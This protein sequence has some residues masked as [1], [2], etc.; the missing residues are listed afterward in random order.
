MEERVHSHLA[1]D[2]D[3][4]GRRHSLAVSTLGIRDIETRDFAQP[5]TNSGSYPN[6]LVQDSGARSAV[7]DLQATLHTRSSASDERTPI[8]QPIDSPFGHHVSLWQKANFALNARHD[9]PPED[10]H[11]THTSSPI[12]SAAPS[13]S[14]S[15]ASL[16]S[17]AEIA[18]PVP[19]STGKRPLISRDISNW[20]TESTQTIKNDR[21]AATGKSSA[22]HQGSPSH[23]ADNEGYPKYPMQAYSAL[24]TQH[25]PPPYQPQPHLFRTRSLHPTQYALHYEPGVRHNRNM[26]KTGREVRTANT[27][28][29]SSSGLFTPK[30]SPSMTDQ[31]LHDRDRYSSPFLHHTHLQVPKET[32]LAE[33]DRDSISGNKVINQY[34]I[35]DELGRGQHGKVKLGRDTKTEDK[36]AIKIVPRYSRRRRLGKIGN[37]ENKVKKEVAILK[38]A[39]HEHVVSLLEVID[40]PNRQKVYLVLEFVELGEIVWRK[41]GTPEI[42]FIEKRRL[43]REKMGLPETQLAIEEDERYLR[44]A[45]HRRVKQERLEVKTRTDRVNNLAWS[46]ELGDSEDDDDSEANPLSR[47]IT[48]ETDISMPGTEASQPTSPLS[49]LTENSAS[50]D[51]PKPQNYEFCGLDVTPTDAATEARRASLVAVEGTMYGAYQDPPRGRALSMAAP[52]TTSL[53]SS[54]FE[55]SQEDDDFKYVPCLTMSQALHAFRDTVLGLEYLHYQG[56]IHRDIK[57]ANLLWTADHHVKISD[58]GVSYLGKPIRE[59]EEEQV[60]ENEA[61]ELDDARELSKTV[62]TPAFYAPE[63]C[64]TDP[65]PLDRDTK[66]TGAIDIWALGVTLYGMIFG[67]L[68]FVAED[69]YSIYQKI[70]NDE[71][72]IS[73]KR[74][75]A[76]EDRPTS[77]PDSQ[78]RVPLSI[79]SNKRLDT[80]LL[81]DVVEDDLYDLLKRL[82]EKDPKKRITLKEVKYH[83]WVLRGIRDPC[84][85]LEETDPSRQSEGGKIEVSNEDIDQAVAKLNVVDRLKSIVGRSINT[86]VGMILASTRER[87]KRATSTTA[88]TDGPPSKSASNSSISTLGKDAKDLRRGSLHGDESIFSALKASRETSKDSEHPL[89][90]SLTASPEPRDSASPSYFLHP[91]NDL[92]S[93]DS[94]RAPSTSTVNSPHHSR[95]NSRRH[96]GRSSSKAESTRTVKA[97]APN[98]TTL[99]PPSPETHSR[100]HPTT[101]TVI[102]ALSGSGLGGIFGG[103]GRRLKGMRSRERR[104]KNN[105]S[106]SVDRTSV[107]D[108]PHAEP[109]LAVSTANVPGHTEVP[110]IFRDDSPPRSPHPPPTS[111]RLEPPSESFDRAHEQF[112]LR[113]ALEEQ[114][115]GRSRPSSMASCQECPPSV[116]DE[117]F[118]IEPQE[119][120]HDQS[121]HQDLQTHCQAQITPSSSEDYF[122]SSMHSTS[123]PSIP[124]VLSGASS[125]TSETIPSKELLIPKV[126]QTGETIIPAYKDVTSV[127]EEEDTGYTG[128][129]GEMGD[130]VDGDDDED[131]SDE[132]IMFGRPKDHSKSTP[133]LKA[134]TKI[135]MK[136]THS[137]PNEAEFE[138]TS[139]S[140]TAES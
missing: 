99:R 72:F 57:P 63:L 91:S 12:S 116:E 121:Q 21:T 59:E 110:P 102:E 93:G 140:T 61:M 40:D 33:I 25:H 30:G 18:A 56:I 60:K 90:Q 124:S 134:E 5:S 104:L 20:S 11:Y 55:L 111:Y 44:I 139:E 75:R 36:V 23:L 92:P 64:F 51:T 29:I 24:Q 77:R 89:A 97:S 38:K 105:R 69:E 10:Y 119:S 101:P 39:R 117:G 78:P 42:V 32:H 128:D 62:G 86:A 19:I 82:L 107:G 48:R 54:E 81:Y 135:E 43:D 37:A 122:N 114:R 123:N 68:P 120:I 13:T 113:Q 88:S 66:I 31:E 83:P 126:L 129:L 4:N 45:Y 74:L 7:D 71:V 79:N 35:L 1:Y 9:S 65:P 109:T 84:K 87:R 27:T 95:H 15:S 70:S 106:P 137:G 125:V 2:Y 112:S 100:S 22:P 53:L 6:L 80:E 67:R 28:P 49:P 130:C 46:L 73:R 52:S 17:R 41:R 138:A 76:V 16:H 14:V 3:Q 26:S 98:L 133:R 108:D 58:F 132:G 8:M 127:I 85:W 115:Q 136:P 47:S 94:S 118:V 34:E 103:A 131:D 96:P 50:Q